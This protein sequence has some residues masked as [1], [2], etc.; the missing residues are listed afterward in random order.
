MV[1][2][3]SCGSTDPAYQIGLNTYPGTPSFLGLRQI[4]PIGQG[5]LGAL[6]KRGASNSLI[7]PGD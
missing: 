3:A 4:N 6:V 2:K 7:L 1:N 5:F